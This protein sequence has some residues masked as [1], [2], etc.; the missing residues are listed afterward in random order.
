MG[1]GPVEPEPGLVGRA[2]DDETECGCL[3]AAGS[4]VRDQ[5]DVVIR[6]G[7]AAGADLAQHKLG[8]R[9]DECR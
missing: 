7:L 6:V 2:V 9:S 4:V 5:L 8:Q 1:L 3:T